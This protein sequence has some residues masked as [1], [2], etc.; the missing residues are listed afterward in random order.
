[1]AAGGGGQRRAA[2]HNASHLR[3]RPMRLWLVVVT[4]LGLA[5][6]GL[7]AY[8]ISQVPFRWYDHAYGSVFWTLLGMH[9]FHL[10][11]AS[12]ENLFFTALTFV[13]PVEKKHMVDIHTNGIYWYF[14][15]L[16]WVPIWAIVYFER[17]VL[18]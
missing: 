12:Y 11:V 6:L 5:A 10:I 2:V 18:P 17:S 7:R 1:V 14:V 9:T 8:E 3:L 16:V 4:V 15:V 13:G